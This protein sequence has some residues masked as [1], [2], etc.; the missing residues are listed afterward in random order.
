MSKNKIIQL[1]NNSARNMAVNALLG[2]NRDQ[3]HIQGTLA[4]IF[5]SSDF[6]PRDKRLATELAYGA[7]RHCITLDHFIGKYS[8]RPIRKIDPIVFQILRIGLYQ[9]LFMERTPDFAAII[10]T[11]APAKAGTAPRFK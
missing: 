6:E 2:F 10:L 7:C 1:T 3:R 11:A 4:E 8:S 5:D 9:L